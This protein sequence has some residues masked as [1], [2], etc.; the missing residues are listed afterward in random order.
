[1]KLNQEEAYFILT[2]L[3]TFVT[4]YESATQKKVTPGAM[5]IIH[6][7]LTEASFPVG[8]RSSHLH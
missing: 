2:N 6:E 1:M 3:D 7:I 5:Q 8:N 4:R